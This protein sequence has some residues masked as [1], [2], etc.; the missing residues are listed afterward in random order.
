M[1]LLLLVRAYALAF[2]ACGITPNSLAGITTGTGAFFATHKPTAQ[3]SAVNQAVAPVDQYGHVLGSKPTWTW[4]SSLI[5]LN[6]ANRQPFAIFNGSGTSVVA[7]VEAIW[8]QKDMAAVTGVAFQLGMHRITSL[9]NT[10]GA[11][12]TQV[13]LQPFDPRFSSLPNSLVVFATPSTSMIGINNAVGGVSSLY[14]RFLHSEETNVAAQVEEVF[15][16]W[17]PV[18]GFGHGAGIFAS[19]LTLPPGYGVVL[20]SVASV[21][22]SYLFGLAVSVSSL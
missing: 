22:G 10:A 17:P 8:A 1:R 12:G 16:Y 9:G 19:K 4:T 2:L 18:A 7:E 20:H 11:L 14:N 13:S 21:A 6:F 3:V 15:P 5:N